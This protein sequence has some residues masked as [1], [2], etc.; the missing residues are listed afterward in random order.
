MLGHVDNDGFLRLGI[1]VMVVFHDFVGGIAVSDHCTSDLIA[2]TVV[3][4]IQ[5][6]DGI[7]SDNGSRSLSTLTRAFRYN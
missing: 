4:D 6:F 7:G 1:A 5:N 3:C 2:T